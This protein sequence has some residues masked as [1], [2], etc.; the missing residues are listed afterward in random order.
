MARCSRF[1]D[2]WA[3]C[4]IGIESIGSPLA[5]CLLGGEEG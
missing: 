1:G 5:K 2:I 4:A 3:Y